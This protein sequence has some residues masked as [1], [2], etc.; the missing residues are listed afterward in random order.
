MTPYKSV[1]SCSTVRGIVPEQLQEL[2]KTTE[3]ASIWDIVLLQKS[4]N[5]SP[6][7]RL[8]NF[9]NPN[10]GN[11]YYTN[12]LKILF[13]TKLF[14]KFPEPK[15]KPLQATTAKSTRATHSSLTH[16]VPTAL[17]RLGKAR[18][19]SL[20]RSMRRSLWAQAR[21]PAALCQTASLS[22]GDLLL[23]TSPT[24][25][26]KETGSSVWGK[27]QGPTL[28]LAHRKHKSNCM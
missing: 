10:T 1:L 22:Q 16:P 25:Q 26:L 27:A 28:Y 3:R 9:C 24:W 7:F 15:I 12:G 11:H 14:P 21:L 20:V 18:L 6:L 2:P 19:W 23:Q 8:S 17:L 4:L 5:T 13:R